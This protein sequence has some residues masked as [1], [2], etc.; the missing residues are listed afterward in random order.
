M[1]EIAEILDYIAYINQQGRP[2][3]L[4]NTYKGVSLSLD[5][6]IRDVDR[7]HGE[8]AVTT[9]YGNPLSLLPATLIQIHSDLFPRPI[10]ARVG[11][12]DVH[13]RKA[14]LRD[15]AYIRSEQDGRKETRIQ[16]RDEIR[17]TVLIGGKTQLG[18]AIINDLSIEG[19][20]LI[21][22]GDQVDMSKVYQPN[23]S[24]RI[25]YTLPVSNQN[26][27]VE[28]SIPAKVS[29]INELS[30]LSKYRVGFMTY[31]QVQQKDWI[32]RYIFDLQTEIFHVT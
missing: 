18:N 12:V 23:T 13:Q 9:Q 30:P 22:M 8:V 16:L 10:Q 29:N 28:I 27:P 14:I 17:V 4:V 26:D 20:S 32:R 3:S 1:S 7:K 5:V 25:I 11:S 2:L 24:V 19:M 31:P 21:M 6:D 15:F